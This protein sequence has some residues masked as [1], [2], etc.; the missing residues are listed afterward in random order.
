[1]SQLFVVNSQT[2]DWQR[3]CRL[4]NFLLREGAEVRWATESFRATSTEGAEFELGRG[5]FLITDAAMPSTE[6]A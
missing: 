1:M 6:R 2:D 5:A 4:I 3:A